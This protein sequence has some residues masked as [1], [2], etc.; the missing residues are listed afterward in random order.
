MSSPKPRVEMFVT[1]AFEMRIPGAADF[2]AVLPSK[3]QGGG[4]ALWTQAKI[5]GDLEGRLQP[6]LG[7]TGGMLH[8]TCARVSS[9]EKK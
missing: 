5:L 2:I 1:S 4:Q 6:K 7:L 8:M 9:R 3:A